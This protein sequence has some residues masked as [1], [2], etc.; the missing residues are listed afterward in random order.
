MVVDWALT[1]TLDRLEEGQGVLVRDLDAGIRLVSVELETTSG[2]VDVHRV[3][4][5]R[6][7][8][9]VVRGQGLVVVQA[10]DANVALDEVA[11]G[12]LDDKS[13]R[14]GWDRD[15]FAVR[16]NVWLSVRQVRETKNFT[17]RRS[18]SVK[19]CFLDAVLVLG[20]QNQAFLADDV[21]C[22]D[23]ALKTVASMGKLQIVHINDLS[24]RGPA[25]SVDTKV[26]FW[27]TGGLANLGQARSALLKG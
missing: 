20:H 24:W 10:E 12:H 5:D 3:S 27:E 9:R 18:A 8:E 21:A 4:R 13:R 23:L 26:G 22:A 14:R 2:N 25:P 1:K 16:H 17:R 15:D 6:T 19:G 7:A 11:V